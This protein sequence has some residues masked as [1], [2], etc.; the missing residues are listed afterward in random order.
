MAAGNEAQ[1]STPVYLG[2]LLDDGEGATVTLA[3]GETRL[4]VHRAVLVAG[5]PV[6]AAMFR[7]DTAESRGGLVDIADVEGPVLRELL[8]YL[9]TLRAPQLASLAPRLLAAADKY[10]VASLKAQCEQQLAAGLTVDNAAATAVLAVRHCCPGLRET[11]VSYINGHTH[12]V[13][14][15]QG[16]A[17]AVRTQPE[18]VVELSRM[19]AE[20]PPEFSSPASP[21]PSAATQPPSG[22][23][24]RHTPPPPDDAAVSRLRSLSQ[25]ERGR[26]LIE[27]ARQGSAEQLRELLAAGADVVAREEEVWWGGSRTALHLAARG[28]HVAA[29]SCLVGAGAEVDARTSLGRR[30]PLHLAAQ[31]GHAG[32]VRLLVG[33]SADPNARD[34][35]GQTPLHRAA[36]GGH[37]ETAAELLQAG[38]D[39]G[40]RDGGGRT[41]LD[42]A[43]KNRKRELVHMLRQR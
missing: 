35:W 21:S 27:A 40:A 22:A 38:A 4:V 39:M 28:G 33:T 14:A 20:T 17:D 9:Y 18:D 1:H 13:M 6:F 12:R 29:A 7:H 37:A 16:W 3:V 43:R 19:L 8:T 15:T 34:R 10:G 24:A 32:V 23:A 26:R 25:Q 36:E 31:W 2:A 41:P 5:S 30:T 11:A 42:V